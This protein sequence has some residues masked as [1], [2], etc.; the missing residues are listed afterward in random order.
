LGKLSEIADRICA[1]L[2]RFEADP[3]INKP[4]EANKMSLTPYYN[5]SAWDTSK[6]VYV[7]YVS[8]QGEHSLSKKDAEK[9][10]AWLDSGKVGKHWG[11]IK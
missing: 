9:Y 8:F 4:K 7:R 2:K 3:I 5:V 6:T 1:H 10:L 11:V